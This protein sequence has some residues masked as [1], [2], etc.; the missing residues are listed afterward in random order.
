MVLLSMAV[1]L[2]TFLV[3]LVNYLLRQKRK[4]ELSRQ[5][6]ATD[7]IILEERPQ[8]FL[9]ERPS[10]WVAIRSSNL[11]TVQTTVGLHD[12]VPCSWN[13]AFARLQDQRMFISAPVQGWILLFGHALPDPSD[14][15]DECFCFLS[16]LSRELGQVQFFSA[17]RA[18]S[19]YGWVKADHGKIVRGYAWGGQT[20]WN[21][22]KLSF[23]EQMLGI[24]C[25]DYGQAPDTSAWRDDVHAAN[26]E[27][28]SALAARWSVDP[29]SLTQQHFKNRL[30]VTGA[31]ARQNL[32][33]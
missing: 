17:N 7:G 8:P 25:R 31:L 21:Q 6:S 19:H 28:V 23:A 15:V 22:G 11:L 13:E 32:R 26:A 12:P 27:K 14:D 24:K 3:C 10:R 16:R 4:L 1:I 18:L 29:L 33:G 30:G 9:I 2:G 20:L 5:S